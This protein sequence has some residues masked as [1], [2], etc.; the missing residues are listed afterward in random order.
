MPLITSKTNLK[1][2]KYGNDR[3]G[4]GSSGQPYIQFDLPENATQEELNYYQNNRNSLDFPGV[5]AGFDLNQGGAYASQAAKYDQLRISKFFKDKSRGPLFIAKQEALQLANPKIQ[6]GDSISF[7][8]DLSSIGI[9]ENTRI[10]N[11]GRNTLAQVG[12]QGTGFHFDRHGTVPINPFQAKYE[13]VASETLSNNANRLKTL[14]QT[15]IVGVIGDAATK[16]AMTKLAISSNPNLLIQYA[17]GPTSIGGIGLTTIHRRVNT[18]LTEEG[19]AGTTWGTRA[20]YALT[21]NETQ[22]RANINH[23]DGLFLGRTLTA[24]SGSILK[25]Y[26]NNKRGLDERILVDVPMYYWASTPA[27]DKTTPS[28][29][30]GTTLGTISAGN[31]AYALNYNQLKAASGDRPNLTKT[32]KADFRLQLN[33]AV[34]GTE[35]YDKDN[36]IANKYGISN[37]G[38]GSKFSIKYDSDTGLQDKVNFQ[39]IVAR[40]DHTRDQGNVQKDL[41]K[42][43]IET[44][45]VDSPDQPGEGAAGASLLVFRAFLTAIQDNHAAEY[46]PVKYVGRGENFY[47]YNGFTRNLSFSFKIAP[48]TRQE[49]APLYKKLNYLVSQLYPDYQ[50]F[51]RTNGNNL[52]NG[53]MRAPITRLTIGD[54]IV[55]QPGFFTAMNITIPDDSPWEIVADPQGKDM[56]MYQLPHVL[57]VSCQFTPIHDFLARRSWIPS[58]NFPGTSTN[59]NITPLITPNPNNTLTGNEFGIGKNTQNEPKVQVVNPTPGTIPPPVAATVTPVITNKLTGNFQSAFK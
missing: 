46:S 18:A 39:D 55:R 50:S 40:Y 12:V 48:Q 19:K 59:A 35:G 32:V 14:Y 29:L 28:K 3:P 1:S 7:G 22:Q 49:M 2:L 4:N 31:F 10:Y 45:E 38:Q 16:K 15:K 57:E 11:G 20:F 47:A 56:G 43:N 9:L 51:I 42:F 52:G 21:S 6:T 54:Y 58:G 5:G 17:G 26:D 53:F 36:N 13:Y 44:I 37:P 30:P 24:T 34:I 41:I 23:R 25:L 33:P 27:E 8:S